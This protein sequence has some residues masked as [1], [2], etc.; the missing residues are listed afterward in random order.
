MTFMRRGTLKI[1]DECFFML[2]PEEHITL[3]EVIM[4]YFSHMMDL[5]ER[6]HDFAP[7]F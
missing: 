5:H 4:L 3:F 7:T 6:F 1:Y 2:L